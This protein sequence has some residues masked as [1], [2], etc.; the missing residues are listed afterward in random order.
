MHITYH[1]LTLQTEEEWRKVFLVTAAVYAVGALLYGL[2]ASGEKQVT[3]PQIFSL[4]EAGKKQVTFP[5]TNSL[6]TPCQWR[7]TGFSSNL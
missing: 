1:F 6:C 7:E 3:Y 5:Q 4:L 2:L